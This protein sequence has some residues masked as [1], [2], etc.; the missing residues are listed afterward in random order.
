MRTDKLHQQTSLRVN[1]GKDAGYVLDKPS[2]FE[3]PECWVTEITNAMT[4]MGS[5]VIKCILPIPLEIIN[6]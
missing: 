6:V 5:A 4:P 1:R 2:F 3:N